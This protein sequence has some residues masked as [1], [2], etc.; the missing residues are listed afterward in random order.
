VGSATD[1]AAECLIQQKDHSNKMEYIAASFLV[2]GARGGSQSERKRDRKQVLEMDALAHTMDEAGV[3]SLLHSHPSLFFTLRDGRNLDNGSLPSIRLDRAILE[4]Y[5]NL[6]PGRIAANF[7]FSR[8]P[9][10]ANFLAAHP[11]VLPS[12]LARFIFAETTTGSSF[13]VPDALCVFFHEDNGGFT[14]PSTPL[15]V[16]LEALVFNQERSSART[17]S[18]AV[19][20]TVAKHLMQEV[21]IEV[22]NENSPPRAP[23]LLQQHPSTYPTPPSWVQA[24]LTFIASTDCETVQGGIG[25]HDDIR[26]TL[27]SSGGKAEAS[28]FRLAAL[29]PIAAAPD[30]SCGDLLST[31]ATKRHGCTVPCTASAAAAAAAVDQ[32]SL[33]AMPNHSVDKEITASISLREFAVAIVALCSQDF[34]SPIEIALHLYLTLVVPCKFTRGN[35]NSSG[36]TTAITEFGVCIC[37]GKP[38]SWALF[39][40]ALFELNSSPLYLRVWGGPSL[41]NIDELMGG[42]VA[43][44]VLNSGGALEYF[45][46]VLSDDDSLLTDAVLRLACISL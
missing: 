10:F 39:L 26:R 46:R 5:Q 18:K 33:S 22:T 41:L 32:V 11:L 42:A 16:F 7:R 14:D 12:V 17:I 40:K 45:L 37:N 28:L 1:A 4:L 30:V 6:R 15:R 29:S 31:L 8:G 21:L 13:D 9:L 38:E 36:L 23:S 3:E 2:E 19:R 20:C 35:S 27:S 44:L 25:W 34:V 24:M 43:A